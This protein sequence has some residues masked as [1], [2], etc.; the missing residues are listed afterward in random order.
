MGGFLN[1]VRYS[2]RMM[3]K[4]RGVTFIA[5]FALAL[6]IGANTSIFSVVNAVLL[7]PL[8]YEKPEQL[9]QIWG[10][11]PQLDKA[12]TSPASFLDW[13]AQN[14]VFEGMAAYTSR[15]FNLTGG[16]APERIISSRVSS[17]LFQLLGVRPALGRSF[18]VEEDQP[19]SNQVVVISHG[20]WRRRFGADP[21]IAGKTIALNDQKFTVVGVMPSGFS[22][23]GARTELWTP[24]AFSHAERKTRDTNFISVVARLK[25]GVTLAG[26]QAEMDGIARQ[27]RQQYPEQYEGIGVKLISLNEQIVGNVQQVLFVLLGVVGFVLLIACANVAN[28]LLARAAARQKEIAIRNALGASRMRVVRQLLT[29]SLLLAL[30]GGAFGF[31]LAWWGLDLL[32]ALKPANIPRLTQI[33]IDRWVFAFTFLLSLLTG[34]IFGLIPA[35]QTSNANV[36]DTLKESGRSATGGGNRQRVRNLLVVSEVALSLVLLVGAGLMIKSFVRLL[37]VDPGFDPDNVLTMSLALPV[38]KYAG[39][40]QQAAFFQQTLE[41][42]K[43]LPGVQFAGVTTDLPLY[44]GSSTG[45][46]VEGR[47]PSAP[48]GKPLTDYHSI[49]PDY[50]RALGIRLVKGRQFTERDTKDA[51]GV[52]V[53]NETLA[54]QFFGA[55]DPIGRRLGLSGPTDWREIVGVVDDVRNYGLDADV[56]PEAYMPYLQNAPGYLAGTSSGMS[57]VVRAASDPSGLTAAIRS[58]VQAVD[59]DQPVYNIQTME[60]FLAESIAQRRFNV[61]L[62]SVFAALALILA[63]VGIYGVMSYSVT[64]RTHEIGIRM[65]LGAQGRDV[66]RL[67]VGQGLV[68]CL[69]GVGVGLLAAFVLTRFLASL[70]YGVSAIDFA[71]Y[72]AVSLLIT[73]VAFLASYIPA[74]RAARI[75]PMIA[76]RYE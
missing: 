21:N 68:L 25:P 26:A 3:L 58:S 51:P 67:V 2:I 12:P 42:I 36:N 55:E 46:E 23:P 60:Q 32:V 1:D 62:L 70:L 48:G 72:T 44:G 43:S 74:R 38:S 64:Q 39:G 27:Q 57:L 40:E 73:V 15:S 6:G 76:L 49:S 75:D 20:L 4:N 52:V 34:L 61:L 53:I 41:R 69:I 17:D 22:F 7:R 9:V 54:K 28:L 31:L 13:R 24:I 11:Q 5:V 19:G 65:A 66:L 71:T 37:E 14:K 45:F 50:F 10:T 18:L 8:P 30:L 47:A 59:K 33:G 29:E 56:K 35:W 63:A 16:D